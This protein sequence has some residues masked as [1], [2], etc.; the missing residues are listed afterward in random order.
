VARIAAGSAVGLRGLYA[1]ALAGPVAARAGLQTLAPGRYAQ[2]SS[3]GARTELVSTLPAGML[4]AL[5][6]VVQAPAAPADAGAARA[7]AIRSETETGIKV[8]FK[9]AVLACV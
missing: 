8:M 2:D 9:K 1:E 3:P 5:A 6:K 7:R 4:R